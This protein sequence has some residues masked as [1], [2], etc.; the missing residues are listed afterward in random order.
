[1]PLTNPVL[2]RLADAF[3][4]ST[5][6]WDWKGRLTHVDDA[7]VI[8][9]LAG[10]GVDAT[11]DA[12]AQDALTERELRPWRRG[13]PACTVMRQGTPLRLGVHV[14]GGTPA[15]VHIRLEEGGRREAVQVDNEVADRDVDGVWTGEATF[16]LPGDLPLGYHRVHLESEAGD[17]EATLVVTPAFLGF[18][19]SMD[20]H[21][22]WGYATQLY[23][24]RSQESW[25]MGDLADLA[26]LATWSGTQHFAD[27][28]LVNPL[29][30]AQ[31]VPPLEPSPYLPSSRRYVNPL[32]IRPELIP[33]YATLPEHK[34]ARIDKLH[35]ELSRFLA[36]SDQ[37]ERDPIWEAKLDALRIV[38]DQGLTEVRTMAKENFVR[39][40]GRMLSQFATWCALVGEFGTNWRDW[41]VE[42]QRPSSPDV[43]AFAAKNAREIDFY[44]W[45]QWV[46]DN[47]LREAQ[48]AARAANMRVGIM[49]DLAV[50]VSGSSAEAWVL[51]DAF[52]QGI[53]VGAPP[54]HYNQLG[55]DWG[56]APWRPD[57][58]EELS[59][60]P[61]RA[62][63]KGILRHSGGIRVDHIMGLFRLWWIPRGMAPT[64]GAYVRYNHDAMVGILMLEAQR[65]G[66]LVVGEDL[67]TVEPW[68]RDY[69]RDRG[70][71]GT[72][73]AWFEMGGDE[74][75]VPPEGYRE[76]AMASVTTHDMPPTA[77]YLAMDHIKL[78]DRLGLLT[79][80]IAE[81]TALAERTFATWRE[82]L[83]AR[84]FLA[85]EHAEDIDE[86][87]LAMHRWI[88]AS[89][90]RV[91][92]AA[93]TDAVGDHRTQNQPGT[94]DEYPNWRV[95][96]SGPDG[97]P[98][99]LEDVY[100]SARAAKLAAVM[101]GFGV[102]S[103][104][105][106]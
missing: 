65:A 102:E 55:Q 76:Y 66:A 92:N 53:G 96:L 105:R 40:E 14:P 70:V 16:E 64:K 17:A 32:Y 88:V 9:I 87:V 78:Q 61:F 8:G 106:R 21:R 89:P 85:P 37:I 10:M 19:A 36:P 27:Y 25:G 69:L 77:G 45:L 2:A 58:L 74:R 79:E 30:A 80:G 18:P 24:V 103:V 71:L 42:Y 7:T 82:A 98:I 83:I 3:G 5:E 34:R 15:A 38:Y 20:G 94:V 29:H 13:L 90:A 104:G 86:Q 33:E 60:Q 56:Q 11:T 48:S 97:E 22:I 68:V 84:G 41:P 72:S 93:L 39:G 12:G 46:A 81:E 75:P 62:M 57:R 91:L 6:F 44:V 43:S 23:S 1:M 73:V 95:P 35:R 26:D 63:V 54:D 31:P 4:I 49:N 50:G 101:N 47:Q 100:V 28:L 52:A 51:G 67:G 99:T 59:Y